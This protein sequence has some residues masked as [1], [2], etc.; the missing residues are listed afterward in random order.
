MGPPGAVTVEIEWSGRRLA[1]L[2]R[3]TRNRD[4]RRTAAAGDVPT[5]ATVAGTFPPR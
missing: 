2:P 5:A 4:L 1:G 3:R